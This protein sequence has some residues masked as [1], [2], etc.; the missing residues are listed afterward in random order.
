MVRVSSKSAEHSNIL[1]IGGKRN[2]SKNGFQNWSSTPQLS[3][4]DESQQNKG[5]NG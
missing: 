5:S 3:T 1:I 4:W 2:I